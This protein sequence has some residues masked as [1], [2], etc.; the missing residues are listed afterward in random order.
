MCLCVRSWSY[1]HKIIIEILFIFAI[2]NKTCT[3]IYVRGDFTKYLIESK[4]FIVSF[5]AWR[6]SAQKLKTIS[7]FENLRKQNR[8]LL[9]DEVF[10]NNNNNKNNFQRALFRIGVGVKWNFDVKLRISEILIEL[11][12]ISKRIIALTARIKS[13]CRSF[14]EI[15]R[16]VHNSC[17]PWTCHCMPICYNNSMKAKT[18]VQ[19]LMIDPMHRF[20]WINVRKLSTLSNASRSTLLC[21]LL[22]DECFCS[23]GKKYHHRYCSLTSKKTTMPRLCVW[24][25]TCDERK[26]EKTRWQTQ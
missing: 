11:S 15:F 7:F 19:C 5:I 21:Y 8:S 24:S 3:L 4:I 25:H 23:E 20:K 12:E 1:T 26:R 10:N 18:A 6:K 22:S 9:L 13:N 14:S 17:L 16:F 2:E